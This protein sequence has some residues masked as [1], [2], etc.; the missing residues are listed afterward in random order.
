[1]NAR[2]SCIVRIV[3]TPFSS[4]PGNG[5]GLGVEPDAMHSRS[6]ATGRPPLASA[7]RRF[8]VSTP[9]ARQDPRD[10]VAGVEVRRDREQLIL[11]GARRSGNS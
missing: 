5:G 1:M 9:A 7:I 8:A 6:Y 3:M 10:A 4:E 11:G 2:A